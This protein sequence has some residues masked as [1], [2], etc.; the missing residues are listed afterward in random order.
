MCVWMS[1]AAL[2]TAVVEITRQYYRVTALFYWFYWFFCG[3]GLAAY[4]M[5]LGPEALCDWPCAP[6]NFRMSP[7]F[8]GKTFVRHYIIITP[9]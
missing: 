4:I 2:R 7:T 5:L 3:V 8:G 6:L 1:A 9:A